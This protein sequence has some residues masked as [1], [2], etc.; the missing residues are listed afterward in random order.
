MRALRLFAAATV[1]LAACTDPATLVAPSHVP[2]PDTP[3]LEVLPSALVDIPYA[4]RS[5]SQK[6]DIHLPTTG[7]PPHKVVLW[8]HG[9]AWSGGDKKLGA[10]NPILQLLGKGY[11]VVSVNYRL[12][13]EAKWPA[14]IHDVKAALRWVRANAATYKF[15]PN[16]IGVWGLSA[17]AHL[18]ALMGTSVG[19]AGLTDLTLGFPKQSER[20]STVI[21][22]ATPSYFL[23]LDSQLS[24]D[25][26]PLFGG[27]G[28]NAPTSPTSLMLGAQQT[29][30]PSLVTASSPRAH[31]T[32][33]DPRMLLV[34]GTSDCT[35]PY[36]Q[37]QILANRMNNVQ[38][39]SA[40]LMLIAGLGH[41]GTAFWS[42]S[43]MNTIFSW[44][45][46]NM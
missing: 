44:L 36:Q 32:V 20:V 25:G 42:T 15:D 35:I 39:G 41:G 17:G 5:P 18:A 9:G 30:V 13:A 40:Q 37:S 2:T 8:I 34:H 33:G 4:T 1:L 29:T 24:T 21:G 10:T 19:V 22:Y 14:N 12:S 6:L 46:A 28:F 38:P 43:M 3:E 23:S 26:C 11:A 16:R 45:A 27:T 31:V 7:T